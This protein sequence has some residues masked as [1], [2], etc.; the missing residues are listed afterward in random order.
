MQQ[1][2]AWV[3]ERPWVSTLLG[4]SLVAVVGGLFE[5][6][7]TGGEA[8]W[9]PL[10]AGVSGA[11]AMTVW[12]V[13]MGK[14]ESP[15]VVMRKSEAQPPPRP[16]FLPQILQ[17]LQ[18][19]YPSVLDKGQRI[20]RVLWPSQPSSSSPPPAKSPRPLVQPAQPALQPEREFY[21]NPPGEL[22]ALIKGIKGQ[23]LTEIAVKDVIEPYIGHWLHVQGRVLDVRESF[24]SEGGIDVWLDDSTGGP[25]IVAGF[26]SPLP[27]R[28]KILARGDQVTVEGEIATIISRGHGR[29]WLEKCQLV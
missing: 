24:V 19:L 21:Q 7:M 26:D 9:I 10:G 1:I 3:R 16:P 22:V 5:Y 11:F 14:P 6:F 28:I 13:L 17:I 2:V 27:K 23:G 18:I 12:V 4:A 8:G 20:L 29:I 25:S 15:R